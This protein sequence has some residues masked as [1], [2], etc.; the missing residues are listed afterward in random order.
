MTM[1]RRAKTRRMETVGGEL[2]HGILPPFIALQQGIWE[3][4]RRILIAVEGGA[5]QAE[6]AEFFGVTR[7]RI[8]GI[9]RR[10]RREFDKPMPAARFL[11]P[12]YTEDEIRAFRLRRSR[13]QRQAAIE[14]QAKAGD[15]RD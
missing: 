4:N 15:S 11:T 6:I 9:V 14:S 12:V 13:E 3:R 10:M 8:N 7:S 1:K 5:S 2:W